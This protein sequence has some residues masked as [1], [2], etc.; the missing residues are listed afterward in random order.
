MCQGEYE[1]T[2]TDDAGCTI[3]IST[4]IDGPASIDNE[5]VVSFK[6]YP[7]PAGDKLNIETTVSINERKI[8]LSNAM[9]Q[10]CSVDI[11]EVGENNYSINLSKLN[12]GYY[13]IQYV[14]E[15]DVISKRFVKI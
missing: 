9:G 4:T 5:K 6:L 14:T 7:N 10:R 8:H 12:K 3:V 13:L 2:V 11:Q 1:V 15:R